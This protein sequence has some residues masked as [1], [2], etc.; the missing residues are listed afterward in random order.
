MSL[1][2]LTPEQEASIVQLAIYH[3]SILTNQQICRD[4]Q[5]LDNV[6]EHI[7][8]NYKKMSRCSIEKTFI[9]RLKEWLASRMVTLLI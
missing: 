2:S 4:A 6:W 1:E 3:L 8:R 9:A 7:C 5:R